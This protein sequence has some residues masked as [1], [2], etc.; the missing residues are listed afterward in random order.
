M[1]AFLFI[2]ILVPLCFYEIVS[3]FVTFSC[4]FEIL[5]IFVKITKKH[6]KR[7]KYTEKQ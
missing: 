2:V 1:R 5:L 6:T 3:I 7:T 4:F